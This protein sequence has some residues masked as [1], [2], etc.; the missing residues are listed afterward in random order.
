MPHNRANTGPIWTQHRPHVA[1]HGPSTAKHRANMGPTYNQHTPNMS[2]TKPNIWFYWNFGANTPVRAVVVA[3]QPEYTKYIKIH[4]NTILF[5]FSALFQ[6][7]FL[8][9][10]TSLTPIQLVLSDQADANAYDLTGRTT[11]LK[12]GQTPGDAEEEFMEYKIHL[13]KASS[14]FQ[15]VSGIQNKRTP[16]HRFPNLRTKLLNAINQ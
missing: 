7:R 3:K 2:P 13:L 8:K 15:D 5:R 14:T 1:Q 12:L 6:A 16:H 9:C 4:Q 10:L 11:V